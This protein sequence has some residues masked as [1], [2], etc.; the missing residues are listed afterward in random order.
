MN[1]KDIKID[2]HIPVPQRH[3]RGMGVIAQTME[4]GDSFAVSAEEANSIRSSIGYYGKRLGREFTV[5]KY[6]DGYRCWRI[7]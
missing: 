1:P 7:R 3:K 5:Q 2:K 4:I 6:K